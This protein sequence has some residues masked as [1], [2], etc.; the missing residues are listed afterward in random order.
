MWLMLAL[1]A[2]VFAAMTTIF[3][4]VGIESVNSHLATAIRTLVVV[5]MAW[6]M[7]FVT[8]AA[9]GIAAISSR[10]WLFLILSGLATGASWLCYFKALQLGETSAVAAIDKLSLV[11]TF[12]FAVAFLQEELTLKSA[13]GVGLITAGVWLMIK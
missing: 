1:L 7:V 9:G 12:I 2:A 6:G 13:L 10:S 8:N 11:I 4:K 5:V 3:A